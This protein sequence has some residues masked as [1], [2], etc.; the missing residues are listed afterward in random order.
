V[1][2]VLRRDDIPFVVRLHSEVPPRR[3]TLFPETPGVSFALEH[4]TTIDPAEYALED[5]DVLPNLEMVLNVEPQAALD[6]LVR[7]FLRKQRA[8]DSTII[9]R[10]DAATTFGEREI[11]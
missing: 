3:Y 9:A 6:A 1:L 10:R 2:D 11:A 7:W 5:F 4:P 8:L